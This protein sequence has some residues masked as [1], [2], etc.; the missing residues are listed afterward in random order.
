MANELPTPVPKD[1]VLGAYPCFV[2]VSED[3][4]LVFDRKRWAVYN[5]DQELFLS[6]FLYKEYDLPKSPYPNFLTLTTCDD[7]NVT[8]DIQSKSFVTED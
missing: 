2:C 8:F 7:T 1:K 4:W 5:S 3:T 6:S